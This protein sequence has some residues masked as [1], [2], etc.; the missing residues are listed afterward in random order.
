MFTGGAWLVMVSE[1]QVRLSTTPLCSRS[2]E[3][4]QGLPECGL[5]RQVVLA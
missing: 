4:T 2:M 5:C 3:T 1:C